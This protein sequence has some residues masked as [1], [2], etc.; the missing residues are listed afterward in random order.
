M[1]KIHCP[2]FSSGWGDME[3][4]ES[5]GSF[6]V[7]DTF[8]AGNVRPRQYVKA[9]LAGRK[10]DFC[11]SHW[12]RDHTRDLDWYIDHDMVARLFL[13]KYNASEEFHGD[14]T[15][16]KKIVK[17]CRDR[18][19][20]VVY[21]GKGSAFNVGKATV[22]CIYASGSGGNNAKS[23]CLMVIM[24]GVKALLCGDAESS[25]I[26]G[27]IKAGVNFSCDIVKM[28]HHGVQENNPA[29]FAS[30]S[31]ATYAFCNCCDESASTFRSW[32]KTA[33][34]R[35][36]SQSIN[37]ASVLYNGGI[38]Y[39]CY[40]GEVNVLMGRNY[41]SAV[42]EISADGFTVRKQ[43]HYCQ[44]EPLHVKRSMKYVDLQLAKDAVCG[45]F[46]N[47]ADREKALGVKAGT[48]QKLVNGLIKEYRDRM[49]ALEGGNGREARE[50]WLKKCG[51]IYSPSV[52]YD[53]I[54]AAV[55]EY[56]KG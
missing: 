50:A 39:D 15:Y 6:L 31:K 46:G 52:A 56:M 24:N 32:A 45:R 29:S 2:V 17:K 11:V 21:L 49:I 27:M 34:S 47:G 9:L 37:C 54:Q 30:R 4:I 18:G 19:I 33:Y 51:F 22:K 20:P 13:S 10:A 3:I 5:E 26:N 43:F 14:L 1:G 7:I 44:K 55:N 8:T 38:V 40:A 28:N 53:V 23:L 35:Y 12:H 48:V 25:T 41:K 36:E 16:Q 42:K